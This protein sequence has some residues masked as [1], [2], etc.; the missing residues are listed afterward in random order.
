MDWLSAVFLVVGGALL[1]VGA[2]GLVRGAS[3]LAVSVGISPLVVGLTVVA[4]GTSAPEM[5]VSIGSALR[6]EPD[7]AVGNVVGS[8]IFNVLLIL[9]MAAVISPLLVQRRLIKLEVPLMIALSVLVYLLA[10]DGVINRLEG[11]LL[12]SGIIIYTV[13]VLR[14]SRKA[15]QQTK[16]EYDEDLPAP[17]SNLGALAM[18]VLLVVGGLALLVLGSELFVDGAVEIAEALGVSQLVI[19]LTIVA[20]GTSM[21][22]LATSVLAG[23]RGHRDIAVGNVVGSNI[24]NILAVLGATGLVADGGVHVADAALELDI[25]VMTAVAVL[26]LP[27][28][29]T[30][31]VIARWEGLMFMGYYAAYTTYLVLDATGKAAAEPLGLVMLGVVVP[32]TIVAMVVLSI[33]SFRFERQERLQTQS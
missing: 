13:W 4:F 26:T 22:E 32:A 15:V 12:F 27:V 2:E 19:G 17:T 1:V 30:G 33:R 21:P 10:L 8:N 14:Q 11:G 9:G 28:L 7:I 29:Y 24:F 16:T 25:P 20:A 3:R 5:A 31:R 23:I 6:G 18:D